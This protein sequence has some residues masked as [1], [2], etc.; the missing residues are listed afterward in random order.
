MP[1]PTRFDWLF[2]PQVADVDLPLSA[3]ARFAEA[4]AELPAVERSALA[5]SEI[6][7]LDT[8]EIAERLGTDPAIVLKLLARARESVRAS[9]AA[10]GRRGLNVLLPFQSLW[11]VGSS[12]PAMR[13]AGL[14]AAA[15]VAPTVA[16]GGAGA[17]APRATLTPSDPLV[18]RAPERPQRRPLAPSR[19]RISLV[20]STPAAAVTRHEPPAPREP[21]SARSAAPIQLSHDASPTAS[22]Q[23]PQPTHEQE[24]ARERSPAAPPAAKRETIPRTLPLPVPA[25]P[26]PAPPPVELP[27]VPPTVPALPVPVPAPELPKPPP[28]PLP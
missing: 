22:P 19:P 9:L 13:A 1:R 24:Q 23:P 27:V 16:V 26:V 5:L 20:R 15:V 4:L 6:G 10:R 17:D 7:G 18:V 14:V 21:R 12:A 11:Q 25:P 3:E 28:L 2:R 8:Y